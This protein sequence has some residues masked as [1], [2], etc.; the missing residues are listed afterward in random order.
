MKRKKIRSNFIE[1]QAHFL[2]TIPAVILYIVFMMIP[3]IKGIFY[4]FTDWNGIAKKFNFI[5][6]KNFVDLMGDRRIIGSISFTLRYTIIL[7]ILTTIIALFLAILLDRK[8]KFRG[9]VRTVYFFPAVLSMIVIGLIFNQ[10]FLNV[11][12]GIGKTL[13]IEFLS[14]NILANKTGAF[15]GLLF[16][17]LWQGL[18]IPTV[19]FLA[20][21]QSVPAELIDAASIDGATSWKRFWSIKFPY[22]IPAM[23]MVVILSLKA[24]LTSF[25][26]IM[27]ITQGGPNKAT[28][29]IGLLI[30][31]YAFSE[32]KFSYANALAVVLFILIGIVSL[33]QV[34]GMN[35]FEVTE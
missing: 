5:G 33:I 12:P 20:G 3:F 8:M 26:H 7:M 14:H 22:L 35:K 30:Y 11:L 9:L 18:A 13:N 19:L 17:N 10:I 16:V 6:I 32:F 1:K 29:S 27:A 34:K 28:E 25:D 23:N 15:W 21:L 24:G 2:Y 4:S 31:R